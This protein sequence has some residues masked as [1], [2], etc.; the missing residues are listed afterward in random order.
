[1][2][3]AIPL[4][5]DR[6]A[7]LVDVAQNF[8]LFDDDAGVDSGFLLSLAPGCNAPALQRH[9]V[10]VLLCGA[11]SRVCQSQLVANGIELRFGLAGDARAIGHAFLLDGDAGLVRFAMPGR[12]RG[13]GAGRQGRCR[14][15][16]RFC[17]FNSFLQE[18]ENATNDG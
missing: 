13:Q 3:I 1:M 6:I 7:P 18:S 5:R 12:R 14:G 9:G 16:H 17:D 10:R 8:L 4:C 2:K 11:L 15:R